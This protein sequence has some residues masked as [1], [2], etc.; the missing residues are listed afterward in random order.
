MLQL[1]EVGL[2]TSGKQESQGFEIDLSGDITSNLSVIASYGYADT[3]DKDA[4]R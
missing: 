1:V 4:N 2:F 3:K